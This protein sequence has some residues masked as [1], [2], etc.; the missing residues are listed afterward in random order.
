MRIL[1]VGEYSRLHNSLKEGLEVLQHDVTIIATGDSFKQFPVDYSIFPR[2]F[3]DNKLLVFLNKILFRLFKLDLPL[4]EK[5]IR[6]WL[7]L[8]RLKEYD[9]VQLINSNAI[10]TYPFFSKFLLK[11]LFRQNK[12][13]FLLVC[14]EDT[15]IIDFM[16]KDSL[17]YS[18]LT[19]LLKD[20][21]LGSYYRFSIKYTQK[22]YRDLYDFVSES[23]S[24]TIVSDLDY[25]IPLPE[26]TLL[27]NPVNTAKIAF[28]ALDSVQKVIVFLGVN[29][30][31]SIKK[32][33]GYFEK[34]LQIIQ[35]KYGDKV[36]II[37]TENAPY[38]QYITLYNHAQ[39]LLDQVYSYDQGYNALEAMAK[40]KVV[41]TGAETEFTNYYN[42]TERVCVNALPD[43][44]YLVQE[45]SY[46]IENPEEITAIG[47]RARAF[48][49]KEHDYV[50]IAEK[51]LNVWNE[52]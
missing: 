16:L 34:A 9:V 20:R 11:K 22:K 44:D 30:T 38:K 40:G 5:G 14:G 3:M 13:S 19:P 17:P 46:L 49:E 45:L 10:E 18:I 36:G 23:V 42:L 21:K 31:S 47:K 32:G 52:S 51:Y 26:K 8:P 50:K 12:K 7:F 15:P 29:N 41:F 4:A 48:I 43:V 33:T 6:F 39:I 35:Q 1:L 28:E 37:K 25:K 24:K 2:Y 27:P